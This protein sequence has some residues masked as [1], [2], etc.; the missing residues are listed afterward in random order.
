MHQIR[1]S[2]I[3]KHLPDNVQITVGS[4]R[5]NDQVRRQGIVIEVER[6]ISQDDF[7]KALAEVENT[8]GKDYH[9]T[10]MK[11]PVQTFAIIQIQRK[12]VEIIV[13]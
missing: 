8:L 10:T 11:S 12:P 6:G 13:D 5:G 7:E 3:R 2:D 4:G 1:I 9:H